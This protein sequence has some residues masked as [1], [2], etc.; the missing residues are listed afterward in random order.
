[1][2]LSYVLDACTEEKPVYTAFA[3]SPTLSGLVCPHHPTALQCDGGCNRATGAE[4]GAREAPGERGRA[5]TP[6][7]IGKGKEG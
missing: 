4:T 2:R 3:F 5:H 1:M 7:P 6:P